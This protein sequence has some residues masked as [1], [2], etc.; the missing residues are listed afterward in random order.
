[1]EETEIFQRE[2]SFKLIQFCKN[3]QIISLF[4]MAQV[5]NNTVTFYSNFVNLSLVYLFISSPQT[6]KLDLLG[7]SL[8]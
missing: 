4:V 1:M 7:N 6:P 8:D 5:F 3:C 2:S